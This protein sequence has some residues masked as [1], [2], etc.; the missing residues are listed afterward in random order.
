MFFW[1]KDVPFQSQSFWVAPHSQ[2]FTNKRQ[3]GQERGAFGYFSTLCVGC[4][5][6]EDISHLFLHCDSSCQIWFDV[7]D[8]LGFVL[9][10]LFNIS[11][12]LGQFGSFIGFS[13]MTLFV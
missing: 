10:T 6:L 12:H 9:V 5:N 11:D 4:C 2:P 7:Y 13:K 8:W 3:F 1:H